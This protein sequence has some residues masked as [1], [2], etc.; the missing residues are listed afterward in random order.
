M[1]RSFSSAVAVVVGLATLAACAAA[2]A[3]GG[4]PVPGTLYLHPERLKKADGGFVDA[5]RGVLFVPLNRE[6]P[7]SKVI[8]VELYRFRAAADAPEGVPP[9]FRLHGGPGWPGLGDSMERDNYYENAV[10]PFTRL[11]DLVLIGQRGIGSSKPNTACEPS[12]ADDDLSD[13]ERARVV[14]ETAERCRTWWE[15]Q[16]FD[17]TGFNVVEAAAD[18]NDARAAL[19]YERIIVYGGS[20]GSHWGMTVMRYH[21]EIVVRAVLTGMEGPDHTY[22]SPAGVFNV[23]ERM[24]ADAESSPKLEG[25]IPEVGLIAALEATIERLEKEPATVTVENPETGESTEVQL[26]ADAVRRMADGYI[27]RVG[28]RRREASWPA[29]VMALYT[30]DYA[31]A[32]RQLADGGGGRGWPTASFFMLDCG[33]G[34]T[35]ERDAMFV[36]H[37]AREI[38]GDQNWFYRTACPVWGADLGD[39]FRQNFD[40]EIPTVIVHG[41]WD[42]ST[43]LENALELAPHFEN[44]KMVLVK[45][46]SHGALGE[47]IEEID[48]FKEALASFIATG[49]M[50]AIPETVELPELDWVV[51][52]EDLDRP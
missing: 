40:T 15:G 12:D 41:D 24:A 7:N 25:H 9:I 31:E 26:D 34:I 43:P 33:S 18:V 47:A 22:D 35:V 6:D 39:E 20:F 36:A 27:G 8:S 13:E 46:G 44:G 30:G 16:G 17:L 48:G 5:E 37:P 42:L 1:I 3:P 23:L 14:R 11:S 38:V 45:R 29:G 32:G 4:T 52:G 28:D 51:P 49:D 19:G 21:P 10:E 2:P 50:S